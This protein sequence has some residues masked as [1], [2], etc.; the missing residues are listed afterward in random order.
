MSKALKKVVL[1]IPTALGA[2]IAIAQ[3]ADAQSLPTNPQSEQDVF[4]QLNR[5]SN[6]PNLNPNDSMGQVQSVSQFRDVAPGDWAFEALRNLVERYGC[7]ASYSDSTYRGDRA[8]TR[9]EFAAGLAACRQEIEPLIATHG[10]RQQ[11]LAILQRLFQEFAAE[12]SILRTRVDNLEER[13][14]AVD[15]NPF[16]TTTKLVGEVVFE[17]TGVFGDLLP[18]DGE[19]R[20]D[21]LALQ[22]RVRLNFDTSF[23]GRDLLRIR[24][25][26]ANLS[27]LENAT[28]TAMA[29]RN[30]AGDNN[31]DLEIGKLLYSAAIGDRIIAYFG[32]TGVLI[33][34]IFDAGST[35]PFT[36]SA[37]SL[38]AT[39][40]N[41]IYDVSN[42]GGAAIGAN[43]DLSDSIRL[44][45]G[46][47]APEASSRSVGDGLL[48]GNF[49][50]GAQLGFSL[51]SSFDISFAYLRNYHGGSSGYDLSGFVG[52]DAAQD[53]FGD[54]ANSSNN[55]GLQV[56]YRVSPSFN[57]G[58]YVGWVDAEAEAGP[59]AEATLFNW[60]V[61]AA[62]PDFGKEGSVLL[63][64][65]GQPPKLIASEGAAVEED[66]DTSYLLS[67]E[68]RY[69][70]TDRIN[71]ASGGYA[72]F[73]PEH[74]S[75]NDTI[76]VGTIR[77]IFSF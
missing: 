37:L 40:N 70:L 45:I 30:L 50:A 26:A 9:Y 25:Q 31:N 32:T 27:F 46:Y 17:L 33:D 36:Y 54:V 51:G 6:A 15:R 35:A 62:V 55:Y 13:V 52:S 47:W 12:L 64:V 53:P 7:I 43:L 29:A 16:S 42:A 73:N 74:N 72:I 60:A 56:N 5:D 22:D 67:V 49:T 69:P 14:A 18:E 77:T 57:V 68:Y 61:N 21:G 76:Y 23:D 63:F 19:E 28:G 2:S 48:E 10:L 44:D 4:E 65:F 20:D 38:F 34:D 8:L 3:R 39:Y 24:L 71:V 75:D 1:S 11:D 41:F 58:G 59:D 66:P